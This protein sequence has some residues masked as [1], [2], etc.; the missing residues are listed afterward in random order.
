MTPLDILVAAYAK[1][2][3]NQPNKIAT[4]ATELLAVV[5]RVIRVYFQIGVRVNPTFF[6]GLLAVPFS[7]P[8]WA[9]PATA[10]AVY[11]IELP[12]TTVVIVV[13]F[14]ERNA[15]PTVPAVYR[16]GQVYRPAGNPLDPTSE[17]LTFFFSRRPADAADTAS[18]ID[19]QFPEAYAEM[20]I[21]ETAIYLA[22]KDG[23]GEEVAYLAAERD[24]WLLMYLSFLE[25]ETLNER[26]VTGPA[27]FVTGGAVPLSS[28]LAGPTS[29]VA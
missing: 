22:M 2:K 5:N 29:V 8:G 4:E 12:D 6:G 13:A 27:S 24:R 11:R 21:L 14:D 15:E 10:E 7:S 17:D 25:H 9:R 23:R 1:S 20:A 19:S 26:R 3:K 16:F 18:A 28:L